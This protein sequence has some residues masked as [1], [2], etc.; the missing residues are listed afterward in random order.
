MLCGNFHTI[1]ESNSWGEWIV[2]I[3]GEATLADS[4]CVAL[5]D[6]TDGVSC[7]VVWNYNKI[8][9]YLS[10]NTNILLLPGT[11]HNLKAVCCQLVGGSGRMAIRIY[12]FD[13]YL[14]KLAISIPQLGVIIDVYA[15]DEVI[16]G[17]V[18]LQAV[19]AIYDPND[20]DVANSMVYF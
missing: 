5:N 10:V 19:E 7:D 16:L 15:A 11:N 17:L 8:L 1:K 6:S 13:P 14:L 18:S 9:S 12:V 4:N 2:N 3:Y 20:K